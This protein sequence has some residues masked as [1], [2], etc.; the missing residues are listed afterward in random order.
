MVLVTQATAVSLRFKDPL[1]LAAEAKSGLKTDFFD[2]SANTVR[3]YNRS[4]GWLHHLCGFTVADLREEL[5]PT[6]AQ[7]GYKKLI[8][9][10]SI[11]AANHAVI[12]GR[13]MWKWAQAN[14]QLSLDDDCPFDKLIL[15]KHEARP[16]A[17]WPEDEVE[18]FI[19]KGDMIA[20]TAVMLLYETGQRVGDVLK[21]R[22]SNFIESEAFPGIMLLDMHQEKTGAR[23]TM[24]M[25]KRVV[26]RIYVLRSALTHPKLNPTV[27]GAAWAAHKGTKVA[28]QM[29]YDMS[30]SSLRNY[31]D[32]TSDALG[33][34]TR[35]PM[36]GL[37]KSAVIRLINAG[38]TE[39]EIM[40]ITG[41]TTSAMVTHYGKEFARDKAAGRAIDKVAAYEE[42]RKSAKGI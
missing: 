12:V 40:A 2:L 27:M 14:G 36:H 42:A 16:Y 6:V 20:S 33:Y 23:V 5:T 29:D 39:S 18:H 26:E 35:K 17:A 1:A 31:L 7:A 34:K 10:T 25:P 11:P 3:S 24:R 13:Q 8:S 4:A 22:L 19:A 9:L 37:R 32:A 28:L 41:H 38:A 21:L 15:A 30:S